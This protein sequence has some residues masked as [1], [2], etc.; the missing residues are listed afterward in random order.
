MPSMP[1]VIVD[2][3]TCPVRGIR[4]DGCVVTALT[5]PATADLPLDRREQRAVAA[6]VGAGLVAPDRVAG[7]RARREPWTGARAAV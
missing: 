3:D 1:A 7:L 2:C 6:L 4:C 5:A